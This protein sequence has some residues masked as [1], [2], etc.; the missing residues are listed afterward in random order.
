MTLLVARG[1]SH[2]LSLLARA[3][4]PAAGGASGG[5]D[6]AETQTL[7]DRHAERMARSQTPPDSAATPP[8]ADA[9]DG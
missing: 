5:A 7:I 1:E 4:G 3:F 9:P 2:P 8:P 6:P